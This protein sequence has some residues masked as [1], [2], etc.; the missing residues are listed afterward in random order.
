MRWLPWAPSYPMCVPRGTGRVGPSVR[1]GGRRPAFPQEGF[2]S[3]GRQ[4]AREEEPLELVAV[5]VLEKRELL[6]GLHAFGDDDELETAAH[7][8]DRHRDRGVVLV[9][10]QIPHERLVELD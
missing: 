3:L 2:E 7:R 6:F 8:D 4:R 10:G 1:P 9:S 5:A